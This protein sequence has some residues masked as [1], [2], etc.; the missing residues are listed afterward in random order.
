MSSLH[1]LASALR[2]P[3]LVLE[4]GEPEWERL[5]V[6][7]ELSRLTATLGDRIERA[8]LWGEL[9]ERVRERFHAGRILADF[10]NR[11]LRWEMACLERVLRKADFEVIVL[12]GGAYLLLDL[13]WARGRLPADLDL[14]VARE[15]LAAMEALLLAEGFAPVKLSSYDQRYYRE[16]MHE[17]PPLRHPE[18]RVEIDI[19]HALL[20]LTARLRA[21]P[22]RLWGAARAVA[23]S[24]FKVLGPQDMVLH[25]AV[26][27][28]YDSDLNNRLRDLVDLDELLRHFGGGQAD[29]WQ[30]LVE[31]AKAHG[32]E[33]PLAY[34]LAFSHRF[35]GT[36]IPQDRPLPAVH[37][38]LARWMNF[39]VGRALFPELPRRFSK[40]TAIARFLLYAR[41]HYLRMPLKVLLPHLLYKAKARLLGH[42]ATP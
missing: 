28:F 11:R 42:P 8:G 29:F 2:D 26:H 32:W 4:F 9:P 14:L 40:I 17:L 1:V 5:L 20:P 21:D 22:E 3:A 18:R 10:R 19:H 24:R 23:G 16:W 33:R 35:L 34:A 38:V 27:L 7:A 30:G 25:A 39:L 15:H 12:K 31:R 41:S 13:P 6:L 37:P 36:P